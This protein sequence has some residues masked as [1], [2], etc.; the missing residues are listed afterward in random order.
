[1]FLS[2][3]IHPLPTGSRR[4]SYRRYGDLAGFICIS[5]ARDR[6]ILAPSTKLASLFAPVTFRQVP[7]RVTSSGVGDQVL[8]VLSPTINL[9]PLASGTT[10]DTIARKSSMSPNST[11]YSSDLKHRSYYLPVPGTPAKS[12][13]HLMTYILQK[14]V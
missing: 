5:Y 6:I 4:T 9:S 14:C 10:T 13:I 8:A 2:V 1:M 7:S 3:L 11:C 12:G